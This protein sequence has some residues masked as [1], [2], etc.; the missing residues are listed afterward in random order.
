MA[1]SDKKKKQM[2]ISEQHHATLG[3]IAKHDKRGLSDAAEVVIE[4]AA[5]KRK[6]S[7]SKGSG[8]SA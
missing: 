4:E 2:L 6:I 7:H 3:K 8:G 5:A 1:Y